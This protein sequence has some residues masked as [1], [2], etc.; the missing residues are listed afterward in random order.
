ME[1]MERD[2]A[3]A[4]LTSGTRFVAGNATGTPN[5]LLAGLARRALQVRGLILRSG[6]LLGDLGLEPAVRAGALTV[7]SWHVHGAMRRLQREGLVDYTPLRLL[8]IP[9]RVLAASDVAL[10]RVGP[11][12]ADGWCSL[13]PS[14]SYARRAAETVPMVIAEVTDDMPRTYGDSRL[15]I[16]RIDRFVRSETALPTQDPGDLDV[17][18]RALAGQVLALL[19]A[20][21]TVQLGIGKV[22]DAIAAALGEEDGDAPPGLIGLVTDAM[23]P[24]IERIARAGGRVKALEVIGS[25]ALMRWLHEN[26]VVQMADSQELHNPLYLARVPNL[27]S[28]NSAI[29]VDIRGQVASESVAGAVIAGVGGSADFAEGAHL[30]PGGLRI[31]ALGSTTRSGASTIVAAHRSEDTVTAAHHSVDLVVTEHGVADLRGATVRERR[32]A[33]TAIAAPEH[34]EALRAS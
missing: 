33:L 29:A 26:P 4:G 21:A 12:D 9:Q 22:P 8:D 32:D 14:A 24:L 19:P 17:A 13:G 20:G 30:S 31:I 23:L 1:W 11:P 5:T 2:D 10:L 25:D 6:L 7:R 28:V 27:V 15:H 16:S 18:G 34:R 3:F